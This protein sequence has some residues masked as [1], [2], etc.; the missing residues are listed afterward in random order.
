MKGSQHFRLQRFTAFAL[1]PV[2]GWFLFMLPH[3]WHLGPDG[4]KLWLSSPINF[5]LTCSLAYLAYFHG[6]LGFTMILSDYTSYD[7]VKPFKLFVKFIFWGL[8]ILTWVA[9]VKTGV[10][11]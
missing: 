8:L 10:G 11:L 6:Y 9:L 3:I 1:A 2:L 4:F 7:D 5:V